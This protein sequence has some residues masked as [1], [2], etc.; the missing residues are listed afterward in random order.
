MTQRQYNNLYCKWEFFQNSGEMWRG[1]RRVV[2]KGD[3]SQRVIGREVWVW[4]GKYLFLVN[5]ILGSC[6]TWWYI[7]RTLNYPSYFFDFQLSSLCHSIHILTKDERYFSGDFLTTPMDKQRSTSESILSSLS[8]IVGGLN[9]PF[10]DPVLNR[11]FRNN[12]Q[13]THVKRTSPQTNTQKFL[14]QSAHLNSGPIVENLFILITSDRL[15]TK[16]D[17]SNK[18][19]I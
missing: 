17:F 14:Y 5:I 2:G 13:I 11:C 1:G 19:H 8:I 9:D 4:D 12:I 16:V 18:V 10:F 3:G 15:T 7:S 6:F